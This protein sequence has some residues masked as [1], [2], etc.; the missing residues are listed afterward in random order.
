[1]AHSCKPHTWEPKEGMLPQVQSQLGVR[2]ARP[3]ADAGAV[4]AQ[5]CRVVW[6]AL[7]PCDGYSWLSTW[8]HLECTTIQ[9]WR[10][11]PWEVVLLGLKGVNPLLITDLRGRKTHIFHQDPEARRHTFNLDHALCWQFTQRHRRRRIL[12]FACLPLPG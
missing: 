11:Q 12:I 7:R 4:T 1:M 6:L 5:S 2:G 8:Q 9:K 10:A 3:G